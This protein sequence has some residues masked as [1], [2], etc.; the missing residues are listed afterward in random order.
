MVKWPEIDNI[1]T[2]EAYNGIIS[3]I[4]IKLLTFVMVNSEMESVQQFINIYPIWICGSDD[5]R[6][7]CA[8]Q[9]MQR[10]RKLILVS[11]L[12]LPSWRGHKAT[13]FIKLQ[14]NIVS[15]SYKKMKNLP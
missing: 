12:N 10:R 1:S 13:K 6:I 11:A 15:H 14:S 7:G 4:L 2:L 9:K 8:R 3:S 5:F